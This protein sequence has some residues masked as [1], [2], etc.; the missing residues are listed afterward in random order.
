MKE[1]VLQIVLS[2]LF[3][4]FLDYRGVTVRNRYKELVRKL[5]IE[6]TI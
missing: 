5:N 3:Y 4:S 2:V 1:Q 6:I